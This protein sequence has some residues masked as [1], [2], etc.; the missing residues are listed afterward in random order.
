MLNRHNFKLKPIAAA[1][2]STMLVGLGNVAYAQDTQMEEVVVTGIRASLERAMDIKRDAAGVVDAISAEDMGKFPDTNLAESLQRITGVSID[3]ANGEGSRVT[4]RGFSG[5]NNLVLLNGRHMPAASA[6]GGNSGAGGARNFGSRSFDFANLA[7][8]AVRGIQVYKTGRAS[9][10]TGGLGGTINIETTRPLENPGLQASVGGKLVHDTTVTSSQEDVTPEVSGLFSWTD[11]NEQFGV[12]LSASYQERDYSFAG[13]ALNEWHV[14]VWEGL[15]NSRYLLVDGAELVNEPDQ[16]QLYATPNDVR[17]SFSEGHRERTNAQLT[18]QFQPVETITLTADYTYA[19]NQLE[20]HRGEQ[21]F[22]FANAN[23]TRAITYLEFDDSAVATPLVIQEDL[24]GLNKDSGHEQQYRNQTNTLDSIGFN[25]DWDV[26]DSFSVQFDVHDSTMESLPTGPAGAGSLDVSV[27][28]PIHASQR[29]V[30]SGDIPNV[31]TTINDANTN[32]N[33]QWDLDDFGTQM[34][35]IWYA[36]QITDITQVQLKGAFEFDNGRFDFGV[37]TR[38]MQTTGKSSNNQLVLGNWGV[39]DAGQIDEG[40]L[41]QF[42]MRG[43]YD[44]YD[45]SNHQAYAVRATDPVA[46]FTWATETYNHPFE[47]AQPF[48]TNNDLKEDTKALFAQV[49]VDGELGGMTTNLTTGFRYETTD[50][51][52]TS[53]VAPPRW[54]YWYDNNDFAPE[55]DGVEATPY[56]VESDYD[57]LLP[58]LDFSIDFTD[59]LKGR[60]SYSKTIARANYNDLAVSAGNFAISGSTLNGAIPTAQASNP[61]LVPLESDNFDLAVEWY[62]ADASF[63]SLTF[64]EKRVA[65][66]QGNEPVV[67]DHFDIRDQ[68]SGPRALAAVDELGEL[69]LPVDDTNLFVMMGVMAHPDEFGAPEDIPLVDGRIDPD[70]HSAVSTFLATNAPLEGLY[71]NETDPLMQFR[72][73]TPVNNKEAK[74]Y[75]FEASVQ[76]FFG[77]TGFGLQANYTIVRGDVSNDDLAN[78]NET[79]FSLTGLSDSANLVGIYEN[80]GFSARLALNWRDEFL[81]ETNRGSGNN[82][83]YVEAYTQVD[84]NV[85]YDINENLSV[86]FEGINLTEENVRHHARNERMMWYLEDQGARYHLGA[87]Y[88]F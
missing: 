24:T 54:L 33:G 6:Y 39:N 42:D 48:T 1:V 50:V 79:Q 52:S 77:E 69:D 49:S 30:F 16:G 21:T 55:T 58:S 76:H 62:Y 81:T 60:F 29:A 31:A 84:L 32:N 74:L 43:Q 9:I 45:L 56:T 72:T 22:W 23:S 80:Y 36:D 61:G 88:T 83:T 71:P 3:R 87:R 12:S 27:A 8:E 11:D 38:S 51:E 64:F 17:Y 26:T 28:A 18:L 59:D 35:R 15:D 82:P 57:N 20:E 66:F 67:T 37:E 73:D 63:A 46:L 14:G 70:F 75:G 25:V 41:M 78:P 5:D 13:A 68:T 10:A 19:E 65:N 34:G 40:L 44:D 7:S 47:V 86:F 4:I 53:L 85:G 2:A